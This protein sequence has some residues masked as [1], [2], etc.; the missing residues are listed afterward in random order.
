MAFGGFTERL[1]IL[2]SADAQGAIRELEATGRTAERELGKAGRASR[3]WSATFTR[4]GAMLVGAA[5]VG[6]VGLSKLAGSASDVEEAQNKV[7][8]VFGAGADDVTSFAENAARSA[9]LSKAAA[10]DAA[11]GFGAMFDALGIAKDESADMSVS[12]VQLAGDMASFNNQD[13]TEML[14]KLR[15]GLAGEVEPLRRFGV[16]LSAAAVESKAMEMGL[17][18]AN[19]EISEAAKVQA[20]YAIILEQTALQQGDFARTSDGM[21]N[22]QRIAK[23]EFENLAAGIG[24]G[25]LP[26]VTSL[27]GGMNDVVGVFTALSPGMQSAIG[28]SAAV[29][30][31]F[32]GVSGAGLLVA[33]QVLKMKDSFANLATTA[34]R[35]AG[36]LRGFAAAGGVITAVVVGVQL[37]DA[38]F[39]KSSRSASELAAEIHELSAAG[40]GLQELADEFFRTSDAAEETFDNFKNFTAPL[41]DFKDLVEEDAA[42]ARL[43]VQE[44]RLLGSDTSAYDDILRD[45]LQ[46]HTTYQRGLAESEFKLRENKSATDDAADSTDEFTEST[47]DSTF[48]ADEFNKKM[49]EAADRLR[50]HIDLVLEAA[51]SEIDFERAMDRAEDAA[52]DLD[53]VLGDTAST[54]ED[55]EDATWDAK[56]AILQAGDSA[57]AKWE[58][59]EGRTASASEKTDILKF[60]WLSFQESISPSSPLRV[61]IDELMR[62]LDDAARPRT[63]SIH[64]SVT[65]GGSGP[66]GDFIGGFT[67]LTG[68]P[69]P[70]PKGKPIVGT[71]HGGEYVLSADVVDRIKKGQPTLGAGTSGGF[72]ATSGSGS[73][74]NIGTLA[75][76][77]V[78]NGQQL[79]DELVRWSKTNGPVPVTVE[80]VSA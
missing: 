35:A 27:L 37:L 54:T 65:G 25:L 32:A 36:A 40:R 49:D 41:D 34:P 6:A 44:L 53:A 26:V 15:S 10:L 28:T 23:A 42:A 73:V 14:E 48:A 39:G 30:T 61:F 47:D 55:I 52:S 1:A 21:A 80:R 71:A 38:A 51:G 16:N 11:G 29:A 63:A 70:G 17:A 76:P 60:A 68:G 7:N 77:G 50:E 75:L 8:V 67:A 78:T 4:S 58:A 19:G 66:G 9:G 62:S 59:V 43:L 72:A 45:N 74:F 46:T 5:A 57:V 2:I 3:D 33:G 64:V 12:M 20:R 31:G 56:D 18:G 69:I 79:V 22:Q 24:Q 13:P